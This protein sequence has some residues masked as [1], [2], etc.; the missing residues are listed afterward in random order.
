[1]IY[2]VLKPAAPLYSR[3]YIVDE[4]FLHCMSEK[5]FPKIKLQADADKIR[6]GKSGVV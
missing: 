4:I 2:S 5:S 3:R 1:M 6:P